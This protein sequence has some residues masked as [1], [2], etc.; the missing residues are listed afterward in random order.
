MNENEDEILEDDED[1]LSKLGSQTKKSDDVLDEEPES[2]DEL[3]DEEDEDDEPYDN[4]D[5]F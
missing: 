4:V 3:A 5:P 2:L 1:E